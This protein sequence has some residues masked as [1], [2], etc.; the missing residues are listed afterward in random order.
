MDQPERGKLSR[1]LELVMRQKGLNLSDI[2]RNCNK[3]LTNS[4]LSRLLKGSDANLTVEAINALAEGLDVDS[5]EL[6][7]AAFGSERGPKAQG[8]D[9]L[10]LL[11]TIQKLVLNPQLMEVVEAWAAMLPEHQAGLLQTIKNLRNPGSKSQ[12]SRKARSK[13]R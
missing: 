10:L 2:E 8:A 11:D 9:P 6:F 3:K 12:R 5:C 4:Y 1:Y 13:K 7:A